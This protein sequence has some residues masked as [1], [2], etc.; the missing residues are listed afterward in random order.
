MMVIIVSLEWRI[1]MEAGEN[2]ERQF[3]THALRYLTMCSR[4]RVGME[5]WMITSYEVEFEHKIGPGGLY[6]KFW[7][8]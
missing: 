2:R 4:C 6:V 3:F 5:V 7:Y 8:T 1:Q